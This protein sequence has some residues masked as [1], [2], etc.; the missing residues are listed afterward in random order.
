MPRSS[1][2]GPTR[3]WRGENVGS[4]SPW[5]SMAS[6]PRRRSSRSRWWRL[7]GS[8]GSAGWVASFLR[9][10]LATERL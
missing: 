2:S 6:Q 3:L 10:E 8:Q 1:S 5:A 9:N 4:T 7:V